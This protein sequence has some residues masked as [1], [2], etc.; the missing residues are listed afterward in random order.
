MNAGNNIDEP[1]YDSKYLLETSPLAKGLKKVKIKEFKLLGEKFHDNLDSVSNMIVLPHTLLAIEHVKRSLVP[2]ELEAALIARVKMI[3]SQANEDDEHEYYSKVRE[4]VF[5][6]KVLP[7]M[8]TMIDE[9]MEGGEKTFLSL[10]G[11]ERDKVQKPYQALLYSSI[12]WVWCSFEV[13]MKELWEVALNLGGKYTSKNVIKNLPEVDG[14]GDVFRRKSININYLAKYDYDLSNRLGSALSYKF[15]FTSLSGIKGA[16]TRAFPKSA[17]ISDALSNKQIL[18]LEA[19]RNVIVHNA[20]VIDEEYC[21]KTDTNEGEVG[22]NLELNSRK[23][24]EY[25]NSTADT[26]LRIMIAVSS[27]VSYAKS[28]KR[29]K[30]ST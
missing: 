22:K 30:P 26:G 19:A 14:S 13:L 5:E 27:I 6:S 25:G 20:G 29:K 28:L 8:E 4:E 15:D 10:L 23:V 11:Y 16:Y 12:V 9:A 18:E 3:A 2:H 21:K 7:N 24:C 17:N 1:I